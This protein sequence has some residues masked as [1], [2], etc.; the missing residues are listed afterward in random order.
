MRT[1]T[2]DNETEPASSGSDGVSTT[3]R[4]I[5]SNSSPAA[6]VDPQDAVASDEAL[7]T[8]DQDQD[9]AELGESDEILD[10]AEDELPEGD[11]L[12]EDDEDDPQMRFTSLDKDQQIQRF[13]KL[14]Q[15]VSDLERMTSTK[16][17]A[18]IHDWVTNRVASAQIALRDVDAKPKEDMANK[19]AINI[20]TA[21]M[22]FVAQPVENLNTMLAQVP[23]LFRQE[24]DIDARWNPESGRVYLEHPSDNLLVLAKDETQPGLFAN[25]EDKELAEAQ[26]QPELVEA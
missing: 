18:R 21:L 19:Q 12:A 2:H 3:S 13:H 14:L 9:E 16:S 25:S 17:W 8:D 15:P 11:E 5:P 20:L 6:T 26:V 1:S 22:E 24:M 7:D 23:P 4:V 10:E